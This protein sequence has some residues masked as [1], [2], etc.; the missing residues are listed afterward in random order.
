MFD[1]GV[2]VLTRSFNRWFILTEAPKVINSDGNST[3]YHI[4]R[5]MT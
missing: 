1:D 5:K 3:S 2:T 4:P